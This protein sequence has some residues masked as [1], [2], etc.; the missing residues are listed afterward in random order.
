MDQLSC[1]RV[2]VRVV[3]QGAFA[4][5]ADPTVEAM[6]SWRRLELKRRLGTRAWSM[7]RP[8][9]ELASRAVVHARH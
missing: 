3:E 2:F 8:L 1:M 6:R 4:R 9:S 7:I 5:A